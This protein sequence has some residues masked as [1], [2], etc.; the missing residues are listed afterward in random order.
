MDLTLSERYVELGREVARFLEDHRE[1]SLG[2]RDHYGPGRDRAVAWQ[3]KLV[4]HGYIGRTL[5]KEY[6][7]AGVEPD[8]L[9]AFVISEEFARA[10][11][12]L[13]LSN[14]GI[15]MFVPTLMVF[16]DEEQK[17][18]SIGPTVRGEMVW[19]QGYS[20]PGSGSDLAS[21][22]TRAERHGD[23]YIVNGQKI[24]TSTAKQADM[25]F[26]LV[27]TDTSQ[28]HAGLSYIV[29]SMDTHGIEV[30]P[31]MTMNG[32]ASFNE[33]FFT[34]VEVPCGNLVG[35]EGQGWMV[36]TT[37]LRFERGMLGRPELSERLYGGC[38]ELA[39]DTGLLASSA[40]RDRLMRLQARLLALKYHGLR[41][42][43]DQLQTRESGVSSL[44]VKLAGCQLNYD[45]C[46]Y[47]IDVMGERGV[48]RFGS[49]GVVDRG[50]WQKTHMYSLGLIIGGGTAQIQ[51]NIISE[52][53][54]GM[55][56][57]P[58]A[59]GSSQSRASAS[60]SAPSGRRGR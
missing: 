8:L 36:G 18:R 44:I 25:M 37:T 20:E 22:Q 40:F 38:V 56:R 17:R 51:K 13:G 21:L 35:E 42:L 11:V 15:D 55:P 32:E 1:E 5:P 4:E 43:T 49:T 9:E 24:W 7:G 27:R 46:A 59:P 54:L 48:L 23:H 3:T 10:G 28:K 53:G 26:A 33:V 30:R 19:C 12:P 34:D 14:Q 52:V 58:K 57:E 2:A 16:G 41:L 31:L 47:A 6:G 60:A 45:L 29:L 50:S 39:K